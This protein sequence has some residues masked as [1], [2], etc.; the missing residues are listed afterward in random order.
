MILN[1]H[2]IIRRCA[3]D[4]LAEPFDIKNVNPASIDIR[5]GSLIMIE[6]V[7][8]DHYVALDIS[9]YSRANPYEL[10]PG[11]FVLASTLETFNIPEDL[12]GVFRLKSSLAREGLA[13]CG[14]EFADPGWHD[15]VATLGLKNF[16]QLHPVVLWPGR[17]IAQLIL[18]KT[19]V[20]D[21]SYAE[22]GR[23]ND[24]A[25]VQESYDAA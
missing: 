5:L 14:A 23:Y 17:K 13:L 6:S 2:E 19:A 22:T 8:D 21:R 9:D 4:R 7:N 15:S 20:P 1:D 11:H 10:K 24:A 3:V 18:M 25:T 12:S 16:R